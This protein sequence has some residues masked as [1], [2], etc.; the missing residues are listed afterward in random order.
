MSNDYI[1]DYKITEPHQHVIQ[2][3]LG[4]N[5]SN[6]STDSIFQYLTVFKQINHFIANK[7]DKPFETI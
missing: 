2:E 3:K 5:R 1:C 7:L 6:R 4:T